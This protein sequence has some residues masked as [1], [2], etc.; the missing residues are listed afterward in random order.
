M[1]LEY[2]RRC[3]GVPAEIGRRVRIDGRLGVI[4]EDLM[5]HPY[6]GVLMDDDPPDRIRPYHPTHMVEYLDMGTVRKM[7]RAQQKY[8]N[9]LKVADCFDGF[10]DYLRQTTGRERREYK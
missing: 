10:G 8:H 7:T 1:S 2:I 6:I 4:A 9:Y 5:D 3:Y